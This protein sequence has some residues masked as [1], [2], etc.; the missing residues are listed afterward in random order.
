MDLGVLILD[1]R[2]ERGL[3]GA[4][5]IGKRGLNWEILAFGA[6]FWL[7]SDLAVSLLFGALIICQIDW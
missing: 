4:C 7:T 6:R 2:H 3:I 1:F 5:G